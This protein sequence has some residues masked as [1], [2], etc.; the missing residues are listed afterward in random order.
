[1][2]LGLQNDCLLSTFDPQNRRLFMTF[3]IQDGGGE[4]GLAARE[5]PGDVEE[6]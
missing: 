6:E 4:N 5:R 3:G 2:A 1:M